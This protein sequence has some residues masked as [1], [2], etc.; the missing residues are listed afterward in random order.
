MIKSNNK[1][2]ILKRKQKGKHI[3]ATYKD[4]FKSFDGYILY[5]IEESDLIIGKLKE[6][7]SKGVEKKNEFLNE[8]VSFIESDLIRKTYLDLDDF[9]LSYLFTEDHIYCGIFLVK[10]KQAIEKILEITKLSEGK[11]SFLL[12]SNFE[13]SYT[14]NYYDSNHNDFPNKFDIQRSF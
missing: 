9:S 10:S 12:D 14:I 11:T 3:I 7:V 2:N 8:N 1:I 4:L 6:I 13:Y 5:D